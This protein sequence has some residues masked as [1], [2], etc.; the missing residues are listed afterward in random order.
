ELRIREGGPN[1]DTSSTVAT[2]T[3]GDVHVHARGAGW[4]VVWGWIWH[5]SARI[6]SIPSPHT[7]RKQ[8]AIYGHSSNPRH[9]P[10]DHWHTELSRRGLEADEAFGGHR[11]TDHQRF[12]GHKYRHRH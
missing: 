5:S 7:I 3:G 11:T 4:D 2:A 12:M 9:D 8:W 1:G 6:C 10:A